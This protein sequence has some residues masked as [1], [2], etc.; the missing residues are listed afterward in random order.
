MEE[1]IKKMV[2]LTGERLHLT[3]RERGSKPRHL[4]HPNILAGSDHTIEWEVGAVKN[5]DPLIL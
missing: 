3:S 4:P 2:F 1:L 5:I